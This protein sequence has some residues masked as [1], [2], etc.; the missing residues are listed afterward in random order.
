MR[1]VR[2]MAWAMLVIA[3]LPGCGTNKQVVDDRL[4]STDPRWAGVDSLMSIGQY[5]TALEGTERILQ[6]ATTPED[7]RPLNGASVRRVQGVSEGGAGH[8]CR[9]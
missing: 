8:L 9:N 7:W 4:R 1:F 3:L 6:E 5:A 2:T